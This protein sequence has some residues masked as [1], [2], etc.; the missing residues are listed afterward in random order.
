MSE[1]GGTQFF[2]S[3]SKNQKIQD[4]RHKN[5]NIAKNGSYVE[6]YEFMNTC[7]EFEPNRIRNEVRTN[8]FQSLS[9]NHQNVHQSHNFQ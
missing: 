1:I 8:Y 2:K 6:K 5:R 9:K 4:G 3:L 7:M